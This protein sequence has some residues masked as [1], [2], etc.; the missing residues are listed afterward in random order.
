MAKEQLALKHTLKT[1]FLFYAPHKL[2][3]VLNGKERHNMNNWMMNFGINTCG[4]VF[5]EQ[6]PL[7]EI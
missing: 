3:I 6:D 4:L 7:L 2:G 1:T 5:E